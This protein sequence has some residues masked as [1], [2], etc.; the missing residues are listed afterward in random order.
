MYTKLAVALI[1]GFAGLGLLWVW[2][3]WFT[4][5][6]TLFSAIIGFAVALIWGV[7]YVLVTIK[8]LADNS[9]NPDPLQ[10]THPVIQKVSP[11]SE[12]EAISEQKE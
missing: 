9:E 12:P 5:N 6:L 7:Q 2:Q 8:L 1:G 3:S 4:S 10:V 11:P